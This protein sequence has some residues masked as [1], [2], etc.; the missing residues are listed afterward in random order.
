MPS[1][2]ILKIRDGTPLEAEG[3]LTY[4]KRHSK[5]LDLAFLYQVR[6]PSNVV[7]KKRVA[8]ILVFKIRPSQEILKIRDC[9]PLEAE[10]IL[11]YRKRPSQEILKIRDGTPLEAEGILTYRKRHSKLLD[12]AFFY[13]VRCP[14]NVVQKKRVA[15]ILVFKIRPSQ[16]ILK[17]R[18]GTPL[19][20]EG[21]L[22]YRKRP[23]QEILKIRDEIL[24]IRD[25]VPSNV[26]Q[27][28]RV[29]RILVFKIRPSQ[30]ILKIRDGT[31][32][33]AEGILTYRKRPSKLLDLAFFYQVRCPSNVVQKKRVARILVFKIRPSQEILKIRDGTPLEAEGILTYRKRPSKLL[34]ARI[35]VFKIRPSQEILKIRD[36]TPLEAEGI[37]TYRKRPSKLLDLAFFYLVR[38][39]SNVVQKKR[40]A[41]ILVFKIRP[42]QEILK[43]RD[44]TPL[45]AEGILTYRK[46][47]S[48]LLDL[49]FFYQVRCPSNVV[50][51]KRVAR[52]LVFK[53]R[54][55]QEILKIRDGT[56]LEAEG[57]L[58]YRKR[59][60]KLLDL[61][62]F[63]Q[64]R[65]P[66][67]VVQ[68]KRVARILVF[69]IRPSQ[70]ILKIRD[71]TP[72]EAEGILTYRK[73]PS[74]LLVLFWP[75]QEI[76]KIRD[77]TPL[78][79]EGIL[80]YRKRPSKLLDLA[81]LYQVR[82]P[83]NVV[84]KKRVARILVFKIRP[85]QEILKI[86]DGTPLEAEGIL[87][88]RK[89]PSKLLVAR[90]LVFKIRPSQ[91][92][93]KIRDGTPLEAEGILTYRKRPS[94]L[95][96]L[97][98]FYLVRCPSNVV[99]KKRVARI[100][101]FK[102]RPSQEILKIR[103]GTPLEA[104]GILTYRKR[105]SKLLDLAFFYQ[106]RCPSNVVQ[107]KRVARILVF[108][109]RPSQEILKIRDGTPLEAEGILTYRKRHSKLLD[110]AFFYQ[111]RCP[112][113]VVQKKRV[114]RILVFKI[115]P[116]QEILKIRDGTPLEAEG[117]LTYRKR[118][119][120]LLVLM[121]SQEILKI[122]D[123]T[124]LE[125][126]GILTYRKRPSKLLDLAFFY[127]VRCPS[128]VV[129]KKRVARILVFKIRASQEILKIRDGTPLEAEG[130]LTYRKRPSKLLVLKKRVAR[131]L[132]F[133]I[134]PSQEIL[135]I[136]D[137][138]PLEAEG[139]LTYRKRP[140]KLLDLAFFYQVRCPS[141]V[142]QKNRV[143]RI[144]VFKI[145]ASQEIL[146]I[147]DGTPLEAEGILTYRKRPSQ[148]ILKIRDG[149]PLEAEGILTYRKR[150]S[151][152]LDL[153]FFY[154]VRCPSNVV[155]KKRV[156]RILVFKIRPSQEI[157]KIRDGTPLEAEGILT[158]RKRP[159]KLLVLMARILVFKIRPSQEILKIRDGTPLEAEGIL[160]YRKRPSKLLDLA[161]FYQVR[162]PSNVVQ[163]K[164]VARILVFKIRASQEILKIR[165]GTPLEAEGILTY[166]KRPS[167]LLVL[168]KRVARILVFKIRPSQEILKIRDG[169]PLEAE[170]ILT[171]R[172]RPSKLLDL[173]FFYQVRCPSNVVQKN[174]VAR[175]LVFKIRASQEILKIRDGTP[176]EAEGI[177]TYRKRPSKL[178]EILKIRDG[179][180]LEAEGILTYRKRPSKLLDLA[181][182][183]QVRCPSNVVQKKRVARILVF[184]IRPSKEILKIRDGT[185]LEAEG[186]LTYRKRPSK[187]LEILKIRDGT[188]L[189]MPSQEIL[190]IRDGTPLEAEGILTYRKRPSKLLDLAFFYQVRCPSNVVQ[191]KRVAR[192]LV[193]KIRASQEILKIR[194]GTPLEAE[195][196]LTYR[197]RPSKLLVLKK[198]VA[199]I[200]VFK[201]RPSQEILKIRDGTPLEAE[202]IL[203]YRKRP[204]KLL[205][206]AFFYQVRCPSNVV[207]KNRVA[208]ILVFKIR[209]SQEILKIRD[210]TPLEAEGILTYRKR[211]SK[212]LV[213]RILVF[214]IRPSQEILKI[215]DGTPLE[216]EGIL[217][218][219]KRHSKLLDLAFFYQVRCP[220]NVVQK[221]RVAR[222]LVFKIRPSQEI[223]K[224]RD[225][226]PLEA[227]G[228]LTYRKRPS[229]LLVLKKR[230]ARILVFK[231][232]PSQEI[233][234]IRDGTPLEAEGI[235][236]YRKRPSKL[237]DLAFFYQVRCPSNVVQKKRVARI[238]VFKIRASQ[239]ILKIRDGTP[240]EAEGILT[241]RKRPSKLLK[242]RVARILVFKIR[243]S[244]EIL[245]IRDGTPLE[246]E[247][248]LTYRKRPSKLLDLAFFYQVRCPSNVVQKNRVARILVFKIRA[249]QE[250]LKIRDG[251]PLEAE[252]ILTY[253]KRPSQE[254]LKIRDGTPLEAEGILTYRKRPSKLLDL[255]FFYQVRCPSNVVQKK[256]VA[257]ILVFK[258]RPSKEILKIRDGTPLEAEGILTYRKRPSKLLV[259]RI[260]VFKIRPSQEILKI[261]DGTP[262]E[263]EGIL[264]YRKRPSKLLDLAFFYLVRCP[265]NV[266]QK[267]RVA[268]ILVFKI[269]PSQEI[270]K[271]RDGTP[272]EAEGI[273]T[274]RK[275][276]SKLLDLA[277]FYQ[278]RCPSNVVQK[279]RV[280]RIL[281][282]KIRPSQ[283]ILKIRDGTPL[284]AEGILTYRKRHS[285]LLD[286][287][288]FYQ[289]RCPS[290]VVQKKRV[291]RILVFKIRPS[292][293]ILKIRDGTP[294]EAEGILTYRKRPSKLLVLM[295]S[296]EILKIRDG[297]PLE[298]EGILTYRK[299]PSKLLDL[300]FFYQVRCPSNVVQKKRVARI[301]LFKIRA[302]QEILKIRDGT[303]LEAEGI[304]T[305]RK[306][307]SKLLEPSQEILKIRDGTPLEAEGILTY[308]K[309]PSKLLDLA[310]FYQVRCPSNV[311]QKKRV[312]RILVFKIRASQEILKIR[313][314]T[315]LEAEGILTYRKRPSQ[316]ILKI[317]DGTP[318][319]AEGIL[320]YRKRPSKLLDLAFFYQV[321]C[322]SN[323][324]QKKR[325][326]RI[327]LFKIRASQEILKIRDGTPLEAEGI[328]TYRKRPSKLLEPSQEILKIRDGTPLEAEGILTYRKRPSKLL[329]LAFFYQVRC[330]SN[331]VQK[332]RVA[333]I[334]VF[335]IRASQEILKIRDGTPLEAEGILTYRKRPSK[336]LDLAF[337][338][339]VR[340]QKKR[341][342]RILVFKI[343]PSQEILKIRDGTPL[344]AEGIL[345]YRKRPSKL[346]DLA[347]FYLVRC[348]SNVVQ[349]KR[350]ARILVFKIRPSQEILKI[351]DGT[352]LEA[353][354]ILTYRKRHSKL[355]DLAFFYQVRCPSNV[356]QK[357]RVARILVFKIRPSQEILKIRDG[358]PLE[359]EGILTYRKR[360]SKLLDLAFFYQVR[361]PSNV[362]QKKR[363]A[364]ILVFKIRPSQEILKIR[365]GTPLEAEGILTYRKRPSKLLVL[366]I[367]K[368]RDVARIL[369]FKIRPSQEIL[370]IRDGTPLEAEGILTYRKRP[371]KLLDLAFFYQVRCPS[372]VVQKKRVARILVF[373]IRA[374][375]EILKIRDGTP[376]EAE[377]ILTY[378]KRPSKLL[379][380]RI[381]VFKIRPSQEILKIR[382]GT[383]LEAEGILTYRKRPSKL[384]DLAFFYQVRCPSNVVQKK[385]VA[386]ILVFK[387]RASQ[388]IL[389]IRDGTP[390]EAE[391]I[392][393]Y[394]K[395]PSKLL[396]LMPSQEI[397]KIRD[398]TPLEAEG[399]LTYRKRHS[400]LLDL[401][402]FYQVRCPS[403]VVH[404]KR[405]ARILVFKIRP[406]QE[407][408]KIRDGTPLEAEGILTYRKRHSKLLDL[409]FFYQ[410][411]CPS[412]V[413]QK[414]R[415]ARI[416]V[417]KIRPSQEILKIRDGTPLEAEGILTYRKRVAQIL[418][419]KIR[420]S[421]EILKIRDGTPLEAEGILTYRKRH[422]KL[423][424]LA[425]FYQVRCPSN[426]VHK[427]RVARILVFKIRPSQ[428][429]LK[430]RDGTPLE[431]EGIL[432]YRKRHSKLLNLAFFYQ[433]RCPSNVVHKKRVARILV[434]KI[435]PS[436]EI[437]KIR[438]GTPLEAE[439]ILTY[440]KRHSKLLD[441]AFFYQ[442]RCPSN[443]VQKKRVAR[444][445]VF[446]IRPSQ[447]I[448][449]IRDGTP[450]EAEGILTY[451]KRHSKLLD[452]AFFY[453]VRC[454]TNVVQ[455]KRVARILV[456]KIRPSQEI[457]KIRDG[458][459]LEVEGIL[460][461]RK[462]PSKLLDLAFFYQVRCPSNVVQKKRVARILV[463]KIRASQEIL[464]IRDGTPLEA[465]GILTYRK[466]PSKLLDLEF[467]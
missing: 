168:K 103:D 245:K 330:P 66:S 13:Q 27:K 466:R 318:L 324:V 7:Q 32:L 102:I 15:R 33:E 310:F 47:H 444:I 270:L 36:G 311:V 170:G 412:N 429:I 402:F 30:E 439:G 433:V 442:V 274:Y 454:P 64:V 327:L 181:F 335:K 305:Y 17:I 183:Y 129:Q 358:T 403:N 107:K 62:F 377:G 247:G 29:A 436:Q 256:R 39:P 198:R 261:R 424:D 131:I 153:A 325:V 236:T 159:S 115:R 94:K 203:T 194:D 216:A 451:R 70:E 396:G 283:E 118:P 182:F 106:G 150:H 88:Y 258:I 437:L 187:L 266:V 206:L 177:L 391:G 252:G 37:L 109:I 46:R 417:Y 440:R 345:T 3:I 208:R 195:G 452:L 246:A 87:T 295:P 143:A 343:R 285:K 336:L 240:L 461:Y 6:C 334:L 414:K 249:S 427:K 344:E 92:I 166:R 227:E 408:L 126:E 158:Y 306:R 460:T 298:A 77:G 431:A 354:G 224:I 230:V 148:E 58:T 221:K 257:R 395:R 237:L 151:K 123:G 163:K 199:R 263:A 456:F 75:S 303:P 409:A 222:I 289:V 161:F 50:Q 273:L 287:A 346:L 226:T 331:V 110:L 10:G 191:K 139:I 294:L 149:T 375:K 467:F 323:V 387:I 84:Q 22:T 242:K 112:S 111:V 337:F 394:R 299:R 232:R 121:P 228:I 380:A 20:A 4:R 376:L 378:R 125:A 173:A 108:K 293:E 269:R 68:K 447:E 244:Q 457:L 98:F 239:E 86:R 421:Q 286:L 176:L 93:L 288:F 225:G 241:Y 463:F 449:K 49:A 465:E 137:G 307:P 215:R 339:Q 116:S 426:V 26:V 355:L 363:V 162:C 90:I 278:V 80:T 132:V 348:P 316:E 398:G 405:V 435:R 82:C 72:L 370:K 379:V 54:P 416:L 419:F 60:S 48:K 356:V 128:N 326:A 133:K 5:L 430:I 219:R 383:P 406:S 113:N 130:I 28:N 193:F 291:A 292:Q 74:K 42:S 214:K 368:I 99:Q 140:S 332:K 392:L 155:Q 105:H 117:I 146:K 201:I 165:D 78:E 97:A 284:E 175:I 19:E 418:V 445:L 400:K 100:L 322:P 184:K 390:L 259:A 425:F 9:T 393:T 410:V 271:I 223:L 385:R 16:E 212:L 135:K 186:I 420:P 321:R 89:R 338:Y 432:T 205:D 422:S 352:P 314:G 388:E 124:P 389:K 272:L 167:K 174:R 243:P 304:L 464:K 251:T 317:R 96:D 275:R 315:P 235:L 11:T 290:N 53:I 333:R 95:L 73:R 179:T 233:L 200:L 234:K 371:S 260:L 207:Q 381:L 91:E 204:S 188:P 277:F 264:T 438:D 423:L 138:T 12:L 446:K 172:K 342:A 142:V 374:S 14:S 81:F 122:R 57:I 357:K 61:A 209:A 254:I 2:E 59:H 220:S 268:R 255:A 45:E 386:R 147:R 21:I 31:P 267:K 67:N 253:R 262:L 160:T 104:E 399:I 189:E 349:K 127:Q 197:K 178:L 319:E 407:I 41:R 265:S 340:L 154:Q 312:A 413:V 462:R 171:Y 43:I 69:K 369:V 51:K 145:R 120:K 404:K 18:D 279:K 329:D 156:A 180:P 397:L 364:R 63:Y 359:A 382:D 164:R 365:D 459:P 443:V 448:L 373:K 213:A 362:V 320:T 434:F 79:A 281:V 347:F 24:K 411:R 415:V 23:S 301:L 114:A 455:K 296:Q 360:H 341:V 34:V 190:K 300:A 384:L 401:A 211:P 83:S 218:Y 101:V 136:R 428:E 157:L 65:C 231:I 229:K 313:D 169:T 276:H 192:I 40:V 196:I 351:R 366:K 361:C 76:L 238:L 217:T 350:V 450:L 328:L 302:S 202:G 71:G 282:F 372:N 1:Q 353:E 8:R 35:L 141:N 367:L 441:L 52:I 248:I 308:R 44:G 25:D 55:S 297:T 185:P 210:G 280:A 152:L 309:R 85:S 56:P 458:T 134:R 144:L 250:I 38:C 119:S 453:Q